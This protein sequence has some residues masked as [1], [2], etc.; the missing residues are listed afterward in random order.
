VSR[1]IRLFLA[2]DH[3]IVLA[4][5]RNLVEAEPDVE[6]VGQA[7]AGLAAVKSIIELKPDV[8]VLDISMPEINGILIARRIAEECPT[9][10]ILVLTFH[11]DRAYVHQALQAGVRGYVLKR[12]AAE[13]LLH[14]I[15][16]VYVGGLYVDPSIAGRIFDG[17]EARAGRAFEKSTTVSLTDREAEV[18]KLAAF[19]FTNKEIAGR[20]GI[21]IK[22]VETYKARGSDKLGLKTRADIVRFA[23]AEGWLTNV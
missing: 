18:L 10:R 22:S 11:E 15:R 2:D 4:G 1:K 19:G 9:V 17:K 21:G 7:T 16:A 6:L 23:S 12:T 5:L 8:A 20:L 3:P 14:A 13:T